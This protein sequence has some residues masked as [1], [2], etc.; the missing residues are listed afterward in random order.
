MSDASPDR[1]TAPAERAEVLISVDV[2]TAGSHVRRFALLSIGACLVDDPDTGF[3]VELRPDSDEVDPAAMR[4]HGLDLD[5]L[6]AEG[7]PPAEAMRRFADWVADVVPPGAK[8]VF[9]AFNAPFDWMYVAAYFDRYL[10][11]N[12]F[13]H[14]ALDIKAYAMGA[15]D[16][17]WAETSMRVLSPLYLSGAALAHNALSDARDQAALFRALRDENRRRRD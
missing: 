9:T 10:G 12:P 17:G 5:V 15:R 11:E 2:E 3:Y 4:V 6:A 8:P 7:L 14:S 13:G 1:P 16:S